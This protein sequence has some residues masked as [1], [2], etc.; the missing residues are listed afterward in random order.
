M[1]NV[2]QV[3]SQPDVDPVVDPETTNMKYMKLVARQAICGVR[4]DLADESELAW[5]AQTSS[6]RAD[7]VQKFELQP[8]G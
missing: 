3:P 5:N 6:R 7:F 4:G 1:S 2:T 8:S